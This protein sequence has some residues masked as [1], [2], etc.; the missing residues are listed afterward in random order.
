[1]SREI[2]DLIDKLKAN[3]KVVALVRYGSRTV[4]DHSPGGDFDLFAFVQE[5]DQVLENIHFYWGGTPV[6]LGL[7]TLDD[8][9][10][11]DPVS[12]IDSMVAKGEV[13]FDRIGGLRDLLAEASELWEQKVEDLT[14]PSVLITRFYQSH[15]LDKVRGRLEV[16]PV[17]CE[18]LLSTN[19]VWLLHIYFK[20]HG[21]SFPGE[22][23]ALA[24]VRQNEPEIADRIEAFFGSRDL[25]RRFKI[26]EELTG[27]VLAQIGG[28]WRRG[29]VLGTTG[30]SEAVGLQKS[31]ELAFENLLLMDPEKAATSG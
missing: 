25:E 14:E 1:M 28:V 12:Y 5:R 10:R 6:D 15:V 29:E 8:L 19:I 4:R 16:D 31:A 3:P 22:K 21:E 20:L 2:A 7:R 11:D 13:L 9:R 27:L 17:F 26:S 23:A 18:M 30:T 24:W